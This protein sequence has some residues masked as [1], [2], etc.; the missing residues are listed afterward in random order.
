MRDLHRKTSEFELFDQYVWEVSQVAQLSR[1][2][3]EELF[4]IVTA[5][6]THPSPASRG[7]VERLVLGRL[8]QVIAIAK[9]FNFDYTRIDI[10]DIVQAGNLGVIEA[11]GH[12]DPVRGTSFATYA[13]FWIKKY[14]VQEFQK[15]SSSVGLSDHAM[16][17]LSWKK[18]LEA[19]LEQR[20]GRIPTFEELVRAVAEARGYRLGRSERLLRKVLTDARSVVSLDTEIGEKQTSRLIDVIPDHSNVGIDTAL[21]DVLRSEELRAALGS[22]TKRESQVLTLLYL[23]G[24]PTHEDVGQELGVSPRQ[25]RQLELSALRKLRQPSRSRN[26]MTFIA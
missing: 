24:L 26:L 2:E 6:S 16:R 11:L 12:F 10:K 17:R 14:V 8:G 4:G 13:A 9:T 20:L 25:V 22:L 23:E 21:E 5:T 3:E 15:L 1:E 7:A 18:R 19:N